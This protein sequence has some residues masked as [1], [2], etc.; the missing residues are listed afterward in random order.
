VARSRRW[1]GGLPALIVL[2]LVL[3]A[4]GGAGRRADASAVA[5]AETALGAAPAATAPAAAPRADFRLLL[6]RSGHW[7]PGQV[8]VAGPVP[9]LRIA[10]PAGWWAV[11]GAAAGASIP[12]RTEVYQGRAPPVAA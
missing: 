8:L 1:A 3:V 4:G 12:V 11:T 2:L 10:P 9:A 7:S 5:G 6:K